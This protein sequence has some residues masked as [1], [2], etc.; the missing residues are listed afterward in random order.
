MRRIWPPF[1]F[2][3]LIVS[4]LALPLG[5]SASPR[6]DF[7][8]A[9]EESRKQADAVAPGVVKADTLKFRSEKIEGNYAVLFYDSISATDGAKR[10]LCAKMQKVG[11]KW[12]MIKTYFDYNPNGIEAKINLTPAW[13]YGAARE[14]FERKPISGKV[15]GYDFKPDT[16]I[17]EVQPNSRQASLNLQCGT[18][19]SPDKMVNI[20]LTCFDTF[21]N[22]QLSQTTNP[23]FEDK[24]ASLFIRQDGKK[25]ENLGPGDF[26]IRLS[27][28]KQDKSLK[29]PVFLNLRL[30]DKDKSHLEGA[31]MA[32]VKV[33]R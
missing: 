2:A 15:F 31:C 18:S 3:V 8:A 28:G 7:D 30:N 6:E 23:H 16:F 17:L 13:A 19:L 11:T 27:L 33:L 12:K 20:S 14:N 4:L 32:Q 1:K 29:I 9:M 10:I 25:T 5:A 26:G 21:Q 22:V 24:T